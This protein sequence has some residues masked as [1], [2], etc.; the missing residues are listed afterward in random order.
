M[1]TVQLQRKF[2]SD[3]QP[4]DFTIN[5]TRLEF[6]LDAGRTRVKSRLKISRC[7]SDKHASLALDGI[8]LKLLG[9]SI[10]GVP[11]QADRFELGAAQ[12]IIFTVP[13]E[14]EFA[15][16]VEIDPSANTRLEGLYLSSGNF[17]TQCEAEGF[18][19]ITYYIDR[20]DVM[21]IFTTRI[22]GDKTR[23]PILLSNGNRVNS[24]ETGDRHWV[25]WVDPFPKPSYLF[26]LIAGDLAR[27]D[28]EFVTRSAKTVALQFYTE[29]HNREKCSHALSS[30][31]KAMKWD[32]ETFGLEYDLDLY[33]VVAVDDF[34][35]GAMENKGLNVFN[36]RYVLANPQT[37][38]DDDYH[39]IEAV[40][41]HE[42]FHNWTG[43]RVTCRDWFQLS[44]KEGLTVFR[45][46]E[47]SSDMTSR[48]IQ[49]ISDVRILRNQQFPEDAGPM[50][51]PVRP[52]S[53]QEINNFYTATIYNK[54]AEVVRMMH[55]LLG[56]EYFRKGMD[57]YFQ[58]HDGQAVTTDN[59][60][61]VMQDASGI[62][63]EQFQLWY[64]QSGTPKIEI[65]R[66]YN[67]R[68]NYLD[69]HIRQ[70]A[71]E[72]QG[73]PNRAFHIPMRLS[74][75]DQQGQAIRLDAGGSLEQLVDIRADQQTLRFN[76]VTDYPVV[77][78]FRGFSAPVVLQ[79]DHSDGELALL[80]SCDTDP[81]N[82]WEAAQ[83]FAS[84]VMLKMLEFEPEYW[85][86][87]MR[88][89]VD[90]FETV[91]SDK[92]V[93]IQLLAEMLVLPGEKYLGEMLELVDIHK[94]RYVRESV[95][96]ALASKHE[97]LFSEHYQKSQSMTGYQ[98]DPEDIAKRRL[99]NTCLNYLLTLDKTEYFDLCLQQFKAAD[100]MTDQMGCLVPIVHYR[101]RQRD[102]IVADFYRQWQETPLV[103]DK[104]FSAQGSASAEDSLDSILPLFEHE[105]Y[106]LQ[107]PNRARSLL[108]AL[109]SNSSAFHQSDGAGYEFVADKILQLDV[110][111]PQVAAR[112]ANS[113][114][115]W[116]KLIPT[117][118]N[119]MKRQLERMLAG[120]NISGDLNELISTSLQ[121]GLTNHAR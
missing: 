76:N 66:A 23:L 57:L 101:N 6:Y 100:N 3:Y 99:K 106:T 63:L 54:G 78:A 89:L 56:K 74:L 67:T 29:H 31:Q 59:F 11:L 46:Q 33:M 117:Q 120:E 92:T 53:Y 113:F 68:Q 87:Q 19:C 80:M 48:A 115:R 41:G 43:N 72:T 16:E 1:K 70:N 86:G 75:F 21:A 62:D 7:C 2:L 73:K 9:L 83:Q 36:T 98:N 20:P 114:L 119:L 58:R 96:R 14:F 111:N 107:N 25:E 5:E 17:C 55:T 97:K 79:T 102:L 49:R 112:M 109:I 38:T 91:L 4:P 51:H 82:R 30:L 26:A 39:S 28:G 110:I 103:V 95:R 84:R 24:G 34:N 13:D 44:L 81:F 42:Y 22:T 61:Q 93:E 88:G 116:R 64:E 40:I 77:S 69:L 8:E 15:C 32:E 121:D 65:S 45:D 52:A 35:M 108:G 90:T 12:L 104:W 71:G 27:V 37:A 47:F 105:A 60:R 85:P 50:A 18:R 118:G 94:V 10:D